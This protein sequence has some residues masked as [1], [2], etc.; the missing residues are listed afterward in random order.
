MARWGIL[1]VD[2]WKTVLSS[3]APSTKASYEKIFFMFVECMDE[4][5]VN[6]RTVEIAHVLSFLKRFEGKSTSRVRTAVSA[7]KFFLRVYNRLDL[8]E[9]VLIDMF[10]K[11]AQNLAPLPAAKLS[12]WDPNKVLN[13]IQGRIRSSSFLCLAK[14]A[15]ILLLLATGWRV[16]DAWK[17]SGEVTFV[18]EAA[19]FRFA[20][21]RKCPI[22]RVYTVTQTVKSFVSSPRICP[23]EAIRAFLICARKKR[24]NQ[25]FLFVSSTGSRAS[26]DTLRRWVRDELKL[27]GISASAGSCR[28]AS[29]SLAMERNMSIDVVMRSAGW[30]SENT[31]RRYYQR[32]VLKDEAPVNLF[33]P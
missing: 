27:A 15:L 20:Q 19:I 32:E 18:H 29:T 8:A 2:V 30:T 17:L 5:S 28:S 14:E 25:K 10:S 31:F 6:F 11:G 33:M 16:D 7:M 22:K 26:K 13:M 21:K 24:D 3:I 23:V 1:D 9:C 4:A 12:V